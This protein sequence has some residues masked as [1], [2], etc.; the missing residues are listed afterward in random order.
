MASTLQS[1]GVLSSLGMVIHTCKPSILKAGWS[2]VINWDQVELQS[3]FQAEWVGTYL[4]LQT[5]PSNKQENMQSQLETNKQKPCAYMISKLV[6][7]AKKKK[8]G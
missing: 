3:D 8:S 2:I 5:K 7:L 4:E 6:S 1:S